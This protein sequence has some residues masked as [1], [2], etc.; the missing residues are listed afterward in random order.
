MTN[1]Q[2]QNIVLAEVLTIAQSAIVS[3]IAAE[4]AGIDFDSPTALRR[5]AD[6]VERTRAIIAAA[7]AAAPK[8]E[9]PEQNVGENITM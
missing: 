7:M 1:S 5:A 2:R 3:A 4:V 9:E 8:K 6:E